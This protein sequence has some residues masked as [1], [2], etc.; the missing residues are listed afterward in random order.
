MVLA[1]RGFPSIGLVLSVLVGGALAAG[2]AN[3]IN[4]WIERDR[5]QIMRRTRGRP[6]P[7][8][9]ISPSHALVFGIVLELV[10][11]ALLWSTVNLLAA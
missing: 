8:G 6:L 1:D 10:A 4:C 2:G 7:A 3:T 11:F 5:D 9:E